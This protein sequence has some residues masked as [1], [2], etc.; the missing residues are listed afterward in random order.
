MGK[1]IIH[2]PISCENFCIEE[3]VN[4]TPNHAKE[5]YVLKIIDHGTIS[6]ET[7]VQIPDE[8]KFWESILCN[9][10]SIEKLRIELISEDIPIR[11]QSTKIKKIMRV[12]FLEKYM[13]LALNALLKISS[14]KSITLISNLQHWKDLTQREIQGIFKKVVNDNTLLQ[15]SLKKADREIHITLTRHNLR[16]LLDLPVQ[17][18]FSQ[19][20]AHPT[21]VFP[22]IA[23]VMV[24]LGLEQIPNARIFVDAMCGAGNV[25]LMISQ[26]LKTQN[27]LFIGAFDKDHS[28]IEIAQKNSKVLK[29]SKIKFCTFDILSENFDTTFPFNNFDLL[30]A[31]PPFSHFVPYSNETLEEIY[32]HLFLIF[33]KYGCKNAKLIINSPRSDIIDPLISKFSFIVLKTI[34]IPRKITKVKLWVISRT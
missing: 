30:M 10:F 22:S 17:I 33:H 15:F 19:L 26:V 20:K 5:K 18:I 8:L 23:Y 2:C 28:W 31:H 14:P 29:S 12:K 4:K 27:D 13:T 25:G 6:L 9:C 1:F 7:L 24:Q 34:E 16:I 32:H 21:P 11:L 3:I